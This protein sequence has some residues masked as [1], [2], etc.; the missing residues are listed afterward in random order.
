MKINGFLARG[1][2]ENEER[3]GYDLED[4]ASGET[5]VFVRKVHTSGWY[6]Y[7]K[8][9]FSPQG[10]SFGRQILK[11]VQVENT[12]LVIIDEIG[13]VELKGRGWAEEIEALVNAGGVMQCWVVRRQLLKR[14]IRQWNI[15]DVMVLDVK[16]DEPE[17]SAGEIISFIKKRRINHNLVNL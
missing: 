5:M 7:G 13:P 15:G 4:I 6:R 17:Q 10:E 2:H 1:I 3:I 9:Y 14:V 11:D 8:Y 12:Q 16:E